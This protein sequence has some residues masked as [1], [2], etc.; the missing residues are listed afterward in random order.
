MPELKWLWLLPFVIV[1]LGYL[2][3]ASWIADG[4]IHNVIDWAEDLIE[5]IK[6]KGGKEWE[7]IRHPPSSFS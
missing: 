7:F 6:G 2:F 4:I 5:R 3:F 1:L